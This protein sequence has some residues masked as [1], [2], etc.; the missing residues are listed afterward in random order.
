MGG[1]RKCHVAGILLQQD[2]S[3][4]CWRKVVNVLRQSSLVNVVKNCII[5]LKNKI[6]TRQLPKC[7]IL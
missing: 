6:I 3:R 7:L 2:R 5:D 1:S 4:V